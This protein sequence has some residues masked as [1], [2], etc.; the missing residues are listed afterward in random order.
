[1]SEPLVDLQNIQ[2]RGDRGGH[3]FTDLCFSLQPGQSAVIT[4]G[5]GAGKTL[6][7][8]LFLGIRLPDSG[9]VRLFGQELRS[10]SGRATRK[11]RRQIGGVGGTFEL[12]PSMTVS[13]N[14][15]LPLVIGGERKKVQKER[16][17]RSL[18][19]FSL[20][21]L[22]GKYPDS[23]TRVENTLTQFARATIANQPLIIIDE[24]LAGLDHGTAARVFESLV[25][26]ALSGRSMLILASDPPQAQIPNSVAFSLSGGILE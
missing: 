2:L 4:G 7:V 8:Q 11:I 5:A 25:R 22:A 14:I 26:V 23:L 17:L 3:V 1:M 10:S 15:T 18:S 6:L 13:E 21:K 12:V 24:P 16:L 9:V 19:E 20:L